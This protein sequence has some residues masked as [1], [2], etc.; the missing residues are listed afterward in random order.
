M[1]IRVTKGFGGCLWHPNFLRLRHLFRFPCR[2][3]K[4]SWSYASKHD[5]RRQRFASH[6]ERRKLHLSQL[7]VAA[8][9][10]SM[11]HSNLVLDVL[12]V[13]RGRQRLK[14]LVR[15]PVPHQGS[16][17]LCLRLLEVVWGRRCSQCAHKSSSQ[18]A[19]E[20][21]GKG[22]PPLDTFAS[23]KED[24]CVSKCLLCSIQ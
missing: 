3:L 13:A 7:P 16:G 17:G 9:R 20:P 21:T 14:V 11:I 15:L 19:A 12:G 1:P 2:V 4:G 5:S 18:F 8:S 24:S 10:T 23:S 6:L 22:F